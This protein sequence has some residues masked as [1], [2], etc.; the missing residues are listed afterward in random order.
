M[1]KRFGLALATASAGFLAMVVSASSIAAAGPVGASAP[2]ALGQIGD[3][4]VTPVH[5]Y[6]RSCEWGPGRGWH[7]HHRSGAISH[8]GAEYRYRARPSC[9]KDWHCERTGPFGANKRCYWR[10]LCY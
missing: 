5:G 2:A 4:L 8:C 6:H 1:K 3:G 9:V 7:R 10:T